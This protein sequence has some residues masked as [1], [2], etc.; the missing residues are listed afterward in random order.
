WER[1]Q[2]SENI[3]SSDYILEI[4]KAKNEIK[5]PIGAC[6]YAN[7]TPMLAPYRIQAGLYLKFIPGFENL[8]NISVLDKEFINPNER[9]HLK[10]SFFYRYVMKQKENE[11]FKS[12]EQ[13]QFDFINEF[14]IDFVVA[15]KNA[16]VSHAILHRQ[17][18][19]ITDSISKEMFI[20]LN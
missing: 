4:E 13:S 20:L 8:I 18:K 3:Y 11:K 5:N 1:K 14:K 7:E 15:Q 10:S 2:D 6:L 12:I 17:K 19:I 16:V 9:H